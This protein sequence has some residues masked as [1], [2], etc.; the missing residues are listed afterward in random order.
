[1]PL[2]AGLVGLP[3]AGKSTLFNALT[4]AGALVGNYPFTTVEPNTGTVAVPDNRL[5]Q[6]SALFQPP[7]TIPAS[8]TFLDIA[9]LVR[10]ASQGEGLG[11]QFLGHIRNVDA[12]VLV[13]RAFAD[14]DVVH[15][16]GNVDP[17]RD[18]EIVELELMLADLD[19]VE[20][21]LEKNE[22][23]ARVQK[24]KKADETAALRAMQQT[25]ADGKPVRLLSLPSE[26]GK[27]P[28]ELAL[29]TALPLLVVAN[30][31][32]ASASSGSVPDALRQRAEQSG[33]KALGISALIESEIS[34]L[35]PS[36]QAEFLSSLGLSEPGLNRLARET[37]TLLDLITFFTAGEKEVRAWTV[38]SGATAQDAAG[39]IHTDFAKGF[40]RAEVV[41]C[42]EL[43]QAGSYAAAKEAG[44]LRLEGKEYLV[45]DGDVMHFRFN[46]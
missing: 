44:R 7:R 1:M 23:A 37:Y 5:L 17:V 21:R 3:N 20:R 41:G 34:E 27:L 2:S 4:H 6:L 30:V 42:D 22:R 33:G 32:E 36:E 19:T 16:E 18:M 14:P 25:L 45:A 24:D 15:V 31:D 46:V 26:T 8:V 40:I 28:R 43:L 39:T 29:L 35:P 38:K 11:N 12:I 9:G 10:G 13:V